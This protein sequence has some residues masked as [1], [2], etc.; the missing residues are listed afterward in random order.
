MKK[1]ST[2]EHLKQLEID[3]Q[4]EDEREH[5]EELKK[6]QKGK[7]RQSELE[8]LRA[9]VRAVTAVEMEKAEEEEMAE[10][11]RK[12]VAGRRSFPPQ[13][14]PSKIKSSTKEDKFE[15]EKDWRRKEE[16]K[17]GRKTSPRMSP[18]GALETFTDD[19]EEPLRWSRMKTAPAPI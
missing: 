15:D 8:R 3:H 19:E 16:D 9:A 1:I 14:Q 5:S 7:D 10:L 13:A 11:R 6:R 18:R 2:Q 17:L 4:A 12:I